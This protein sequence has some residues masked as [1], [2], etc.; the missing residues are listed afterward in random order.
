MRSSPLCRANCCEELPARPVDVVL[1]NP[2]TEVCLL[3]P[4][5]SSV[6]AVDVC[7]A[8]VKGA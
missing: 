5:A 7:A 4:L 8:C 2:V 1:V 6:L 3:T